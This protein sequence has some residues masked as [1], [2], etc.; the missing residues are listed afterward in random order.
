MNQLLVMPR[1]VDRAGE[2]YVFPLGIPYVSSSLKKEGF[3]VYTLNLNNIEGYIEDILRKEIKEKEIDI[4]LTGGL[5]SQ[6][7][8]IK[9]IISTAKNIKQDIITIVGGGIITSAPEAAMEALE[10][11]DYGV[12]G[13]GEITNCKLHHALENNED[14]GKIDGIIYRKNGSYCITNPR[15]EIQNLDDIPFPDYK[16]FDFDKIMDIGA[17]FNG[18]NETNTVT[19]ISSRS[20]PFQCTFCFHTNGKKYRQRSLDNFFKELDYLVEEYGVKYL[21][22]ADELFANNMKRVKE[23]CDRIKKYNIKWAAQFRVSDITSE[24]VNLVKGSN[25]AIIQFGLESADNRI[26]KSMKKYITI[27]QIE[28][29]LKI[30]YDAGITIQGN[31]IFGD[32]EETLE[33]A[34]NTLKW[35]REHIHY[36]ISLNFITIYPGTELYKN[37][38]DKGLIEDEIEYI[39]QGCLS[40][41]VSKMSDKERAWLSEQIVTLPNQEP[42]SIENINLDYANGIISLQ[43]CCVSCNT[44]NIWG[45][46]KMF[47]RNVLTCNKCGK[48]HKIPVMYEVTST[49]D[50]N[51]EILLE[52]YD[53]IAF[54]GI[55]DF[56]SDF[57]KHLNSVLSDSIY[58]VDDTQMKQG[59][60]ISGKVIYSPEIIKEKNIKLVIVPVRSIFTI[61]EQRVESDFKNVK[62]TKSI[63][64]LINCD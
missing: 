43:G 21:L 24:L 44:K 22:I 2:W 38:C 28:S 34:N 17:N 29:A 53:R 61:I 1:I 14:I 50:R 11:V 10:F 15:E 7:N 62:T 41:N 58:Y 39:K 63:L 40:I 35:W 37:A 57:S 6:Y 23:F 5:T 12:I 33:T 4:L 25:C 55:N 59:S 56:F 13:E 18:M 36:G 9:P 51:V 47:T 19:M 30:V 64:D 3:N 60:R 27:E 46:I 54:W 32:A 20:C 42:Q 52:K 26:L 8:L 48:R 49:I 45:N 16:G 31:F